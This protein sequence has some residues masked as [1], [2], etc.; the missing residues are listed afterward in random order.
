[1]SRPAPRLICSAASNWSGRGG[2]V[3][4]PGGVM[5]AAS[6]FCLFTSAI[7]AARVPGVSV[8]GAFLKPI[9]LSLIW[10]KLSARPGAAVAALA[11]LIRL[12]R[13]T[14]PATVQSTPAP[15]QTMHSSTPR[16]LV[17]E[18]EAISGNVLSCASMSVSGKWLRGIDRGWRPFIRGR[19]RKSVVSPAE[20]GSERD[21]LGLHLV[22]ERVA[23][24]RCGGHALAGIEVEAVLLALAVDVGQ[25]NG[26]ARS[27]V[28]GPA[29][30]DAEFGALAP[31]GRVPE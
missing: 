15:A 16:R 4:A 11:G 28:V 18:G 27:Q 31:V 9:W 25:E 29:R 19:C 20:R 7:A 22:A 24:G 12:E 2:W 5:K 3:T 1:M 10:T 14:P 8:L 30:G 23:A 13:G 17:P 26:H 21:Q 6:P